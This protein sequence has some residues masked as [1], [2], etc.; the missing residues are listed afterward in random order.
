MLDATIVTT[1]DEL[2]QIHQLNT[3][4]Y[5]HHVTPE[6]K[7]KEGFVSWL[8]PPELLQQIQ[9]LAP[10]IIVK[11][12]DKVVG[13]ALVT[14]RE[15]AAFHKDLQTMFDNLSHITYKNQP[16]N[17]Y[18]FYCMGQVCIDKAYRGKGIF[19]MLYQHHKKLY[20]KDFDMV[21][22]EISTS[23]IRSQRAHEKVGFET[24][25]NYTDASDEWNVVVWDWK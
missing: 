18:H 5:R 13:Y 6:E 11:D 7:N 9:K 25:Y 21:I 1:E 15:A 19:N 12:G 23:N 3:I 24:I 2:L 10:N 4:N 14:L 17:N 20:S 22:T 16:L 8:Y